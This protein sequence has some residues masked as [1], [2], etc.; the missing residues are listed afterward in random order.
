MNERDENKLLS[1]ILDLSPLSEYEDLA[2]WYEQFK[3]KIRKEMK[4]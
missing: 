4:K 3:K 1:V 2:T